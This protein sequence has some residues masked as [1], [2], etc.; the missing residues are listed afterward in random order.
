[1]ADGIPLFRN[2]FFGNFYPAAGSPIIDSSVDALED[3]LAMVQVSAPLGIA[4]SPIQTPKYDAFGQ[5][6]V[7][8]P[9]VAPPPGL[10]ENVFKDRG[11]VDRADFIGPNAKL[12]NPLD[13]GG[14]DLD[15]NANLGESAPQL[16]WTSSR[17]N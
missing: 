2:P 14:D 12:V 17:S 3:R 6:R 16:R 7:D 1:M 9:A 5:L 11:A 15:P 4:A 10:G 8:D 13:N